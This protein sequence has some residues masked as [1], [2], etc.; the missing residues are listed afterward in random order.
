MD[1]FKLVALLPMKANSERIRGKNFKAFNGKPLFRWMLDKLYSMPEV[2][3]IVINTDARHIL[4]EHGLTEDNKIQ[5]RDRKQELLGDFTSMNRIIE[6]DIGAVDSEAYLM[7]HTTNPLLRVETMRNA[8]ALYYRNVGSGFDSVFATKKIQGRFYDSECNPI[9][10]DPNVLTRTQDIAPWFEDVSNFYL[11]SRSSFKSSK[12]RIGSSPKMYVMDP[13]ESMDIDDI[14]TWNF[15]EILSR[16]S[17]S[18]D[19]F[20]QSL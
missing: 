18:Q 1:S 3:R 19:S 9:N 8:L 17:T 13:M 4:A 10:H 12:A 11:F 15:A 14:E 20:K 7:T 2:E 6:D 16:H 5:I